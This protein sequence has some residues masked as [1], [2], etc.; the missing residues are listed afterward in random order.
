MPATCTSSGVAK[1]NKR[2]SAYSFRQAT[3]AYRW[4]PLFGRTL[5][6]S[7]NRRGK[8]LVCIYTDERPDL[9]R[10]LPN[11]M[12]DENYCAG[13]SLGAPQVSIEALNALV[14]ALAVGSKSAKQGSRSRPSQAKEAFR[15]K[16]KE[17]GSTAA[18]AG[19]RIAA[20]DGV[21]DATE[22]QGTD[23]GAGRPPAGGA[24][25]A[26]DGGRGQRGRRP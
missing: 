7:Y 17:N 5:Q 1:A 3:I 19:S 12:F 8:D 26:D 14:S 22:H 13:M 24:R 20:S 4:H 21:S 9:A 15:A 10:E 6:V 18:R 25:R 23:R 2:H 11:W 16:D